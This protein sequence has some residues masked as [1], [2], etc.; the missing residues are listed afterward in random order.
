MY[1][2]KLNDNLKKY[3]SEVGVVRDKVEVVRVM[4]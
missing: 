1:R 4:T 3:I 2:F